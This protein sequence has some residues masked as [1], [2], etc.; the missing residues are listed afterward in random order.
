ML[1][2][3]EQEKIYSFAPKINYFAELRYV[4]QNIRKVHAVLPKLILK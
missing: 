1:S 4:Q 3:L 2:W